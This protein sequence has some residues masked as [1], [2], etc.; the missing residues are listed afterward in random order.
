MAKP[1]TR[2]IR[3]R[4]LSGHV[5]VSPLSSW[6][7]MAF[8]ADTLWTTL[9]TGARPAPPVAC[10]APVVSAPPRKIELARLHG[11]FW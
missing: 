7:E 6:A 3:F 2:A 11:G 10:L 8:I 1:P 5:R 4:L 9:P